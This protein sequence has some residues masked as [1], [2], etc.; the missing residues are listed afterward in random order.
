V[1]DL[2][3]HCSA[4]ATADGRIK[5]DVVVAD[6]R[7]Y[8]SDG[9]VSAGSSNAAAYVAGVVAVLKA[10]EP[11]LRPTGLL[12]IARQ[13]DPIPRAG[14]QGAPEPR[15]ALLGSRLWRTPSRERLAEAVR[16][17]DY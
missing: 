5:P 12:R 17:F 2:D 6:S 7:A 4:G 3:P 16:F 9:Q 8:F 11:G 15:Q 13:G 1:G 10:V 14:G